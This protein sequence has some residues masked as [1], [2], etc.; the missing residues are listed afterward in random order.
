MQKLV[1][2]QELQKFGK[3]ITSNVS[4]VQL[5][6]TKRCPLLSI[7]GLIIPYEGTKAFS[8]WTTTTEY[9]SSVGL[10]LKMDCIAENYSNCWESF[11][12]NPWR[13]RFSFSAT[14]SVLSHL[15]C[16]KTMITFFNQ[17]SFGTWNDF[18]FVTALGGHLRCTKIH[19]MPA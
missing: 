13:H 4:K 6:R 9:I 18:K 15:S 14:R 5:V 8:P 7:T 16:V 10:R 1:S 19:C 3:S 11:V 17:W 12:E 2:R